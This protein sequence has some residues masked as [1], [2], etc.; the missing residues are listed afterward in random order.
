M[1]VS[2][3]SSRRRW[4]SP[5]WYAAASCPRS[6]RASATASAPLRGPAVDDTAAAVGGQLVDD[7]E[8]PVALLVGVGEA[9]DGERDVVA[10][11][12]C[13]HDEGV[14]QGEP[15][16]DVLLGG[17]RGGRGHRDHP[18][19]PD[20]LDQLA[21]PQV[22]GTEVVTPRRD[23]VCLVDRDEGRLDP[24]DLR[25]HLRV[26][27]LLG[28]EQQEAQVAVARRAASTRPRSSS[29]SAELSRAAVRPAS[30]SE[31]TWSCCSAS[32]GDTTTVQPSSSSPASW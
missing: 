6:R 12:A 5:A 29:D 25:Q 3:T 14:A 30:S 27:Q 22:V 1:K 23:A 28:G 11:E 16:D 20:L 17:Q 9:L 7:R 4:E 10:L 2:C 31:A 15:L 24:C 13:E 32:S 18:G 19:R 8:H 21:E 26:G